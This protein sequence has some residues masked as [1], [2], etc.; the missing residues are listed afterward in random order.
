MKLAPVIQLEDLKPG[1]FLLFDKGRLHEIYDVIDES[2]GFGENAVVVVEWEPNA[3][4][5]L[6]LSTVQGFRLVDS[7]KNPEMFL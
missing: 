4:Q 5:K 6:S 7:K 1:L 3:P 2:F